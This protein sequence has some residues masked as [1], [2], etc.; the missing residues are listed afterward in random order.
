[1]SDAPA[2]PPAPR[3]AVN[4][5]AVDEIAGTATLHGRELA[6]HH[7]D[8]FGYRTL[9]AWEKD[10]ASIEPMQ[11][12]D[13]AARVL[14]ELTRDEVEQLSPAKLGVVFTI[15]GYRVQE[16]EAAFPNGTGST[17]T[18]GSPSA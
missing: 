7:L 8:G 13:V 16:V 14:P 10:P 12:W 6:V 4:L 5:D 9:T 17:G 11:L 1:M 3:P 15:A 18:T 2:K